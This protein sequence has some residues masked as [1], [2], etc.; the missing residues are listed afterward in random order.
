[1]KYQTATAWKPRPPSHVRLAGGSA[2]H[3]A[4]NPPAAFT[5]TGSATRKP[6]YIN[7][8]CSTLVL[9]TARKPP[10]A[11]YTMVNAVPA[12]T[13]QTSGTPR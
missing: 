7:T 2:A 10:A 3:S 9:T 8:N 11:T 4:E 13:A 12:M 6:R 5:A 1:M